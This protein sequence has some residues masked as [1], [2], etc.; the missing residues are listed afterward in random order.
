[1]NKS[2]GNRENHTARLIRKPARGEQQSNSVFV[3]PSVD[4]RDREYTVVLER[5]AIYKKP[6]FL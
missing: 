2:R 4:G 6:S 5:K 3:A 1:M